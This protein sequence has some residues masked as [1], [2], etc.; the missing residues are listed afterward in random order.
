MHP[1][2]H[3]GSRKPDPVPA[4]FFDIIIIIPNKLIPVSV[5]EEKNEV[6]QEAGLLRSVRAFGL[7]EESGWMVVILVD[8]K[9]LEPSTPALRTRCSPS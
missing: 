1:Y 4:G 5:G 9:G 8:E 3:N 6:I 2:S 7:F